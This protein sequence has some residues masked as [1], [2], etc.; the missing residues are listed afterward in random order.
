M[1]ELAAGP[2]LFAVKVQMSAGE[3]QGFFNWGNPADQV[4]HHTDPG[5][6][7]WSQRQTQDPPQ[8][9]FKLAGAGTFDGPMSR[10][11]H[12]GSDF[13]GDQLL[14][15]LE[16]LQ[17]DGA[18]IIQSAQN[19]LGIALGQILQGKG[20]RGRGKGN[21]QNS[22]LVAVFDQGIKSCFAAARAHR[23]DG[24]LALKIDRA[25]Q[26]RW[27]RNG[28]PSFLSL[29]RLL[30]SELAAAVVAKLARLQNRRGR[31]LS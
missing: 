21:P 1:A 2:G 13:V 3:A 9:V 10:V 15:D 6:V 5:G 12:P 7:G 20:D 19:P 17:G 24:K 8:V 18:D 27:R 26:N 14:T 30:N 29:S 25:F 11:V 22:L 28:L 23:N 4:E 31:D 16:Q